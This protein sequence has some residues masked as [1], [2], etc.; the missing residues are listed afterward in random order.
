LGN[1]EARIIFTWLKTRNDAFHFYAVFL[2]P[3]EKTTGISYQEENAQLW[4]YLQG[5]GVFPARE[6]WSVN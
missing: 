6:Y 5:F 3:P 1:L 2:P 4:N